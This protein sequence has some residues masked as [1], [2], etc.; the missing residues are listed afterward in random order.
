MHKFKKYS[1]ILTL[2]FLIGFVSPVWAGETTTKASTKE[3]K[4]EL[5]M[6]TSMAEKKL[7]LLAEAMPEEKFMWRP[8]KDIRSVSETNMHVAGTIYWGIIFLGYKIQENIPITKE[9]K[10]TLE[11]EKNKRK[12]AVIKA[13]KS[14]FKHF[15]N[16][17]DKIPESDLFQIKAY[18]GQKGTLQSFLFSLIT[19]N[20]E[21]LG[22]L[23]AYARM[24]GIKPPWSK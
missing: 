1:I 18:L 5:K 15:K 3:I 8:Q 22:Q 6:L 11:W 23:I 4:A 9:Y 13:L 24:N 2:V 19:H 21:H 10:T 14:S 16:I 20:H 12:D 17:L 7:I